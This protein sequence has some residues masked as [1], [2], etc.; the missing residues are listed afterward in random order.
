[1][2]NL[3]SSEIK[4]KNGQT[5]FTIEEDLDYS[6]AIVKFSYELLG[7]DFI[8]CVIC[9]P[10]V[11]NKNIRIS[12]KPREGYRNEEGL[13]FVQ[14]YNINEREYLRNILQAVI[15]KYDEW[16]MTYDM[17]LHLGMETLILESL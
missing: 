6:I 12:E 15:K 1:M 2:V 11:H 5:I 3:Q 17:K 14:D 9:F 10:E 8:L 7:E 4:N 13:L 16:G